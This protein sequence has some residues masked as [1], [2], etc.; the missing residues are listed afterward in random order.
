MGTVPDFAWNGP[1]VKVE[2][3]VPGSPAAAAGL[4]PGDVLQTIA[5]ENVTSLGRYSEILKQHAPGDEVKV[6]VERAGK[7]LEVSVKLQAR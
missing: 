3:I 6:G 5:G 2:S 1:G 4:Q 7:P